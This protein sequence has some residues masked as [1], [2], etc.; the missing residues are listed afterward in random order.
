MVKFEVKTE[1][2]TLEAID[3]N[4]VFSKMSPWISFTEKAAI[5]RARD[6]IGGKIISIVKSGNDEIPA[7]YT[8][9]EFKLAK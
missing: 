1:N 7:E 4:M 2:G 3:M 9:I 5:D 6:Y 8:P